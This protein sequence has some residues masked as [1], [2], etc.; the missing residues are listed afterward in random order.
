M[1][2][3]L[4]LVCILDICVMCGKEEEKVDHLF[5]H[6]EEEVSVWSSFIGRCSLAWCCPKDIADAAMSWMGGA[7]VG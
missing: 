2:R 1:K 5:L 4:T 6:C 7:I 3:G